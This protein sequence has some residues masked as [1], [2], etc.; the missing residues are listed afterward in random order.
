MLAA[1]LAGFHGVRVAGDQRVVQADA[2]FG[3]GGPVAGP[4]LHGGGGVLRAHD[5]AD[6]GV[7]VVDEFAGGQVAAEVV[8]A[9][10]GGVDA[11]GAQDQDLPGVAVDP[12]RGTDAGGGADD[13]VDPAVQ[14]G[15]HRHPFGLGPI[16]GGGDH[17]EQAAG[18]GRGGDLLV[19]HGHH[20]VGEP[21]HDHPDGAGAGPAHPGRQRVADVAEV[22]G[23][24]PDP[25]RGRGRGG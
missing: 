9:D 16:P 22:G 10:R 18:G 5:Q 13:P 6:P 12:Q 2:G 8:V 1:A 3:E 20:G 15:L 23:G 7:A 21:G 24:H 14:Q 25:F 11:V 4:A 19:E 17:G